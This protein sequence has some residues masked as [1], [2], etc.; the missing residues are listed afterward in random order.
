MLLWVALP[1]ALR[2]NWRLW[3]R[4]ATTRTVAASPTRSTSRPT[5]WTCP[6]NIPSTS[7]K[8]KTKEYLIL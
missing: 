4:L 5:T 7:G 1:A 2:K 8:T 3:R 6:P